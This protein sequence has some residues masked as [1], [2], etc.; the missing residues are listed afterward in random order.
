MNKMIACCAGCLASLALQA[1]AAAPR[2]EAVQSPAWLERGGRS[3]P[4]T[5]G[6][7]LQP[8]DKLQTGANARVRLALPEGS[9]VKLG[10]NAQFVIERAEDRGFF[11][12][13]L[14]V[15]A[16]AF[17]FTTN[18]LLRKQPREL[19]IKVRNVTIGI[20]GTDLWGKSSDER[21]WVVLLEGRI[22]VNEEGGAPVTIDRPNDMFEKPRDK[23]AGVVPVDARQ[24]AAWAEET[25]LAHE[26]EAAGKTGAW[27][28]V[29]AQVPSRDAARDM[30]RTL[31]S[32][33]FAA[34]ISPSSTYFAVEVRAMGSEAQARAVMGN[35]RDLP[36][37]VLPKVVPAR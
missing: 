25:E 32:A 31:R 19:A 37:V 15:L 36:G 12:G 21:T 7:E 13:A 27:K 5:P 2:V 35:L 24:V 16:G 33:G 4:L 1:L 34:E 29:V 11:R 22:A 14:T 26:G 10:E 9:A 30:V 18:P 3:V 6:L 17:R 28:I 23:A 20:R 8:Q